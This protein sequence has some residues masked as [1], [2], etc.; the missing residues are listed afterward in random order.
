MRYIIKKG[1]KMRKNMLQA[2]YTVLMGLFIYSCSGLTLPE[3]IGVKGTVNLPIRVGA[4]NLNETLKV[5]I[6]NAFSAS[7]Q[8]GAIIYIVDYGKEQDVQTFCLYIPI[9]MTKDLNPSEFLKTIDEQINGETESKDITPISL[10]HGDPISINTINLFNNGGDTNNNIPV[11][12]LADIAKYVNTIYFD[13]CQENIDSG[14]G[15]DFCLDEEIP[16]GLQMILICD[17]IDVYSNL[18]NNLFT[19]VPKTLHKG[20]NKFGNEEE[21]LELKVSEYSSDRRMLR[22][23]V[24]FQSDGPISSVWDTSR[25]TDFPAG[26]TFNIKGNMSIFRKWREAK[27]DLAKA[28]LASSTDD[29]IFGRY[30]AKAIDLSVL[31]D[32]FEGGF[33]FTDELKAKI[34]MNGPF[35]EYM[36]YTLE[37]MALF[38]GDEIGKELCSEDLSVS[39]ESID[40]VVK[41]NLNEKGYY[42]YKKLPGNTNEGVGVIYEDTIKEIFIARP[43][44]LF[45]KF[46][47]KP[48]VDD[49]L[50]SVFPHSFQDID[51]SGSIVTTMMIML[52]MTLTA[53]GNDCAIYLPDMFGED[54]D[55]FGRKECKALFDKGEIGRIRM[56]VNFA[57]PIFTEGWLFINDENELFPDLPEGIRLD[58]PKTVLNF[59]KQQFDIIENTYPITPKIRIKIDEGGTVNIPK[60]MAILNINIEMKGLINVGEH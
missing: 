56:T 48:D 17:E 30:P 51:N 42:K 33:E 6:E 5:K 9:K 11:V 10:R 22:F 53:A 44:E 7:I 1:E 24:K 15:L 37:M 4:A 40:N 23:T 27:I 29:N 21:E 43:A 41:G 2:L 39:S 49:K 52:P 47:I 26:S 28:L 50:L 8:E 20:H 18:I 45:F 59:T 13:V 16:K 25:D 34:Y 31:K 60:D 36:G 14:L 54:E 19:T 35:A 3:K 12:S 38:D 55:L 58:G 46:R 32:Y 57:D